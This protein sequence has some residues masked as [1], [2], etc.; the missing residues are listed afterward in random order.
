[1]RSGV[2]DPRCTIEFTGGPIAEAVSRLDLDYFDLVFVDDSATSEQRTATI[3]T[4]AALRPAKA[5][6]VIHDYEFDDYQRAAAA[7]SHRFTF[8][9]FNPMT[10]LGFNFKNERQTDLRQ[11]NHRI[12]VNCQLLE[13][14]DI[15]GWLRVLRK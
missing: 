14:D 12:K 13:P 3:K 8:N 7:F 5:W 6:I 4:L 15:C 9:A 1:M 10:G 2:D 11:L